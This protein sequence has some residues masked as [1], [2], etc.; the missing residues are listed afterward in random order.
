MNRP[1]HHTLFFSVTVA[2]TLLLFTAGTVRADRELDQFNF[3]EGLFIHLDY[4]SAVEEY[5]AF[6]KAFPQSKHAPAAAYRIGEAHLRKE[7]F[8]KA[9]AAYA[10]A[11]KKFPDAPEAALG[12][13]NLGRALFRSKQAEPALAAF[14]TAA[15]KGKD[16]VKEE[17]MVGAGECLIELGRF[18]DAV[19]L[20]E[21]FLAAF[22]ASKHR[23]DV[24]F[25]RGW[26][27]M[28]LD[29]HA[30][31][32]KTF[33]ALIKEFPQH[34][35]A[36]KAQLA[37]SDCY[38]ALG[39]F[40][41]AAAVL[42]KL[43]GNAALT[44]DVLLRQAWNMFKNG[45]KKAAAE[46]FSR[47]A[48]SYPESPLR[49]SALF[50]AGIAHFDSQAYAEAITPLAE[51]QAKYPVAREAAEARF[52]HGL[53]LFNLDKFGEAVERLA[54]LVKD[55]AALGPDKTETL[56]AIYPQAL[57]K[58]GRQEEAIAAF[59]AFLKQAPKS[60]HAPG[61][62]YALANALERIGK[63]D[64]AVTALEE[65]LK[66][67]P[68]NE[69]RPH[70]LFALGEYLYRLKQPA[71]ALPYLK[72]LVAKGEAS[73]KILYRLG[74]VYVDLKQPQDSL[75]CFTRLA[76]M[77]SPLAPEAAYMAGRA[78]EDVKDSAAAIAAYESLAKQK[79]SDEFSEKALYRLG[80]LY[81]GA[82][83][84][85]NAKQYAERFPKGAY[86]ADLRLKLAENTFAAGNLDAA[87]AHYSALALAPDLKPEAAAAA[88][89]GLAWT[90]LKKGD[91]AKADE[92]FQKVLA[93][94]KAET[95]LLNDARLQRGEIAYKRNAF[96]DARPF[97]EALKDAPKQ[98]ERALYMTGW[99]AR[100]LDDLQASTQAFRD[101]V[102]RYPDGEFA[103]DASLRLAENLGRQQQH[104]DA[105]KV[106]KAVL[107]R[108]PVKELPEELLQTYGDCLVAAKDWQ[109]LIKNSEALTQAFPDTKRPY[110][111]TFRL[112]L[113]Y[114]ALGMPDEAEKQ[115]LATIAKTDTIEAARAQF[116]IG[117]LYF[118]RG[119]FLEAGKQF[120]RV[121]MLYDYEDLAPKSLY[122]AAESF[123]R[124][125]EDKRA[126]LYVQKLKE[127][128]AK[129]EWTAK[130]EA[131]PPK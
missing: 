122:H 111:G 38:T 124:A 9:V 15:A 126:A 46:T 78:A 51:I 100:K 65:L 121:E 131:P 64:E 112:G 88:A 83:A 79:N 102:T 43:Q 26:A 77:K 114:Q 57:A 16:Q 101:T 80:F 110:L 47:F 91:T 62:I 109:E 85:D 63:L 23:V 66:T 98:A 11:T 42:G 71:R 118:T 20:F 113:A 125:G 12:N 30:A 49:V 34:A 74:W 24:L 31:A 69:L 45:D 130:A 119:Q 21:Q 8:D 81:T 127:K 32:G 97:F 19:T 10:E 123:R 73:D 52:W 59:R 99:C 6:L 93:N 129:S 84:E 3:A 117:S 40:G 50:N 1:L 29:R 4:D 103:V 58:A 108:K 33:E 107:D 106:L 5:Q 48:A 13:Y 87:L 17:A 37:L 14:T 94:G 25:S 36:A 104:A 61:V 70:V 67:A 92:S 35:T 68:D 7:T 44:E 105:C 27:E 60:A 95:T 96:K 41:E 116:N 120:L 54:P 128:Y 76:A 82:Q 72:E 90:H 55:P 28:K 56:G 89:Y 75:P 2:V 115:F 18:A 39:R 53:C 86:A 22:P